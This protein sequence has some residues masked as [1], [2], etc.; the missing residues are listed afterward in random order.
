MK[1]KSIVIAAV[2]AI[3]AFVWIL[4]GQFGSEEA[5][6]ESNE[7]E[8][9]EKKSDLM[10]VRVSEL[11]AIS[12]TETVNVTGRT[13][14][15]RKVELRAETQGQVT[16]L[17]VERGERVEENKPIASLRADDRPA[18][19]SEAR[20][21]LRQRQIEYSAAAKL[22][23]KG[24]RSETEKAGAQARL[25][26]ARA[27]VELM[28]IDIARTTFRAP[29]DGIIGAGHVEK[30]D[31]VKVGDVTATVVDL[32]PILIVGN[33][34]ERHISLIT[35]GMP[36]TIRLIDGT[37]RTGSV[38]F[39][40]SLADPATRTYRVEMTV[41]NTDLSIRD[42]LTAEIEVPV[43]TAMAHFV[44]PSVLTLNDDG[45]VGIKTVEPDNKVK[46]RP[47]EIIADDV[48]GIWLG[49]LPDKIRMITV[50]Q[51]FVIDGEL[52]TP[53]DGAPRITADTSS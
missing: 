43:S 49:G 28:E 35:E 25:D 13:E 36:G 50:G 38:R 45:Q 8:Q 24:F 51:E 31:Y 2:L 29:F 44:T 26:A 21:T 48:E 4:S 40:A 47:V 33:V 10:M 46:F 52:V 14:A 20:A 41:P 39:V 15:S 17:Y 9:A 53:V 23:Q 7:T 27:V 22:T 34:S 6:V 30:G 5:N 42:G 12:R 1:N 19:L 32:D 37:T 18:K 11:D 3:V 16:E